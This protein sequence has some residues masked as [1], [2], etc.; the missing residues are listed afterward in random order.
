[1]GTEL[2][3][4]KF[5]AGYTYGGTAEPEPSSFAPAT[6]PPGFYTPP[7]ARPAPADY[8]PPTSSSPG[9]VATSQGFY[10]PAAAQP[11]VSGFPQPA[12]SPATG[13]PVGY[14]VKQ[15]YAGPGGTAI[16]AAVLS[17]IGVVYN[18][19][20]AVIGAASLAGLI[21]MATSS[22]QP[23]GDDGTIALTA[24]LGVVSTIGPI[25]LLIGGI[26]LLRHR[27]RGR[28][29]IVAGCLL[30]IAVQLF[31]TLGIYGFMRIGSG[32]IGSLG[33]EEASSASHTLNSYAAMTMLFNLLPAI[34]AVVTM[35]FALAPAT[36][37]W[38]EPVQ[39][40]PTPSGAWGPA[41]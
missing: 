9:P 41:A 27:L 17:F 36:R 7:A 13:Y 37:R 1:M 19:T 29:M 12:S 26:K 14:P 10:T 20:Y 3:P 15:Q 21:L 39:R 6:T 18:G 8:A 5:G 24:A 4:S 28:Q 2:P 31:W 34:G 25:L 30:T 11:P 22:P 33:T 38:C 23:I 16:T 40:M 32:F 35:A